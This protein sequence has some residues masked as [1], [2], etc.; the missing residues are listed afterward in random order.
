MDPSSAS[1][2]RLCASTPHSRATAGIGVLSG[3]DQALV[4]LEY[5]C[6]ETSLRP[7]IAKN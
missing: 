3:S 6:M 5:C 4:G 1:E 2:I 7:A